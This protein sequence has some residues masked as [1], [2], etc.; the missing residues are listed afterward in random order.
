MTVL[1]DNFLY[2]R[3]FF[4]SI[5]A[6]FYS[7]TSNSFFFQK[8]KN[9]DNFGILKWENNNIIDIIEKPQEFVSN[10]AVIGLYIFDKTFSQN[11]KK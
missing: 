1:G 4:N 6:I 11:L 8:V 3:D 7:S 5:K 10:D 2:G 9:P